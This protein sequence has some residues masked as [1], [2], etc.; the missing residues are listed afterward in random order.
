LKNIELNEVV[1]SEVLE[2]PTWLRIKRAVCNK[3]AV[4]V[5]WTRLKSQPVQLFIDEIR[6]EVELTSEEVVSS[7][8]SPLSAFADSAY[9]FANRVAEGMSLYVNSVEIAFDSG[10]F[11]GSLT[12]SRLAVESRSPGWQPISDLRYSRIIDPAT[13]KL[14]MFKTVTWQLLRIEASAQAQQPSRNVINA[15]LRLITSSGK[16]RITVKKSTADGSVLGGRIQIILDDILWI[17]TLP[18]VRSAIAF[19]DHIM[20]IVKLAPEKPPVVPLQQQNETK[21]LLSPPTCKASNP[22][23]SAFRNFDFEQTSY[24][25][26]VGKIDLHL[27]DDNLSSEDYPKDW[28]IVCGAL[29]VTLVRLTVDFYP[30]NSAISDRNEWVRY[31]NENQCAAWVH[32]SRLTGMWRNLMSQNWVVRMHDVV[33]QCVTDMDSKKDA[34]FNLFMS[35]RRS[36]VSMP[37]DKPLF[38]LELAS[39]YHPKISDASFE[40]EKIPRTFLRVEL[41][42]PKIILPFKESDSLD[43]R[44]PQ[45]LVLSMSTVLLTNCE[46]FCS[47]ESNSFFKSLSPNIIDF[48][49]RTN[50]LTG[51]EK[52]KEFI[53]QL[54]QNSYFDVDEGERFWIKTSPVWIDTDFGSGTPS[55][56][57]LADVAFHALVSAKTDKV[58][59]ALQPLWRIRAAVNHY[60]FVAIVRLISRISM[61][62]DQLVA[63]G[64]FFSVNRSNGCGVAI[65]FI[66]F[67]DEVELNFILPADP[68]PTPYDLPQAASLRSA[69]PSSIG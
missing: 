27:C 6:V 35:D 61:F 38:H 50:L 12:L 57:L 42:M 59:I 24:H 4:K 7:G 53:F 39:F 48:I 28:D 66:C 55:T 56:V 37:G 65:A 51:K 18:Q 54:N 29:Q 25:V 52:F 17:A 3:I 47:D 60:Q 10:V 63:D 64:K 5:P 69:T 40:I 58:N 31:D 11:R 46:T 62:V 41:L 21:Q 8:S 49:D 2:L 19:Y 67:V 22:V 1:L 68:L 33:V 14:L 44:L 13:C 32:K 16:S 30:A 45:R 43:A 15:P 23:S 34:L 20:K 36:K 9:G 26:Y